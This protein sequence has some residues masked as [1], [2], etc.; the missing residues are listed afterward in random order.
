MGFDKFI[1]GLDSFG[2]PVILNFD[3]NGGSRGTI[4]GAC[5]SVLLKII[6]LA[7]IA[8]KTKTLYF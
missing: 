7:I 5:I 6:L 1:R 3:K 8:M 2:Y 4:L